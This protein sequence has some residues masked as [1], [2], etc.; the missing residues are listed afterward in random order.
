MDLNEVA[1]FLKVV[2][3]GSFTQAARSLGMPNSTVSA[4]VSDLEKRLGVSLI[5]RTTRKLFI[6]PEGQAFYEKCARGLEEIRSAEEEVSAGQRE[7]QGLLR[8]TAPIELG[9]TVLPNVIAK[10]K[11]Q[12]PKVQ[13]ELNLSDATVDLIAEGF[14]LAIRGGDLKDSSLMAKKLGSV[15]FA[16]F[17]SASYLKKN[18]APK[19]P[20]DL[21][22]HCCLQF[23]P[24][25]VDEWKLVGPKAVNVPMKKQIVINELN[26]IKALTI[27][28]LGVSLMPTFHC[29]AEVQSGKL[30]RVLPEWRSNLRPVHF[31]YGGHRHA[32]PKVNAFIALATEMIQE[33]LASYEL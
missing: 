27:A 13:F 19:T 1:V 28:G 25:G 16:P 29:M 10:F 12:Y 6:T 4:K 20:K 22:D 3:L 17:A 9:S 18:P 8:L 24:I 7:P 33:R 5:R 30:V 31:V 14:D 23:T 21:K 2:E 32:S 11:Q 15:Y 26:M